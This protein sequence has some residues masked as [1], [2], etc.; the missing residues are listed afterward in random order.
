MNFFSLRISWR[1]LTRFKINTIINLSGLIAA[2]TAAILILVYIINETSFDKFH[3]H[4]D[5]IY[6]LNSIIT[7]ADGQEL[8]AATTSGKLPAVLMRQLPEIEYI[9]RYYNWGSHEVVANGNRYSSELIYWVDTSFLDIFS[10]KMK[11]S[12]AKNCLKE[13]NSIVLTSSAARRLFGNMDPIN[14]TLLI[15]GTGYQVTGLMEDVPSNSHMQFEMLASFETIETPGNG[16]TDRNGLSFTFYL[17]LKPGTDY[18]AFY[19]K[20]QRVADQHTK[21]RFENTGFSVKHSL[22][23]LDRVHLYSN[24]IIDTA[25]SGDIRN[26]RIFSFMALFILLIASMNYINLMTAQSEVRMRETGLLKVLGADRIHLIRK[27][28]IESLLICFSALILAYGI[29][30]LLLHSFSNIMDS[31][32]SEASLF[33]GPI[34]PIMIGV[35]LVTGIISGFYPAWI[36]SIS[37][38]ATILKGSKGN[39]TIS[40]LSKYLVAFQFCITVFLIIGVVL[41]Q[42]QI[43]YMKNID[44]GFKKTDLIVVNNV[45]DKIR[46]SYKSIRAEMLA[47]PDIVDVTQGQTSPGLPMSVQN[48]YK[49]GDDPNTAFMINEARVNDHYL[50]TYGIKLIS[51]R[52]F[53]QDMPTDSASFIINKSAARKLGLKDPVGTKINVWNTQGTII[54]VVSDFHFTS[55]HRAVEPLVF[56]HHQDWFNL[57]SV[58]LR[59]GTTVRA[60][61]H[62]VK[63]LKEADPVYNIEYAFVDQTFKTMYLKEER[64]NDLITA[65]SILAIIISVMGLFALT[66]FTIRRRVKEVGIRKTMGASAKQIIFLL[67]GKVLWWIL[68]GIVV[69]F[70]LIWYTMDVWL[71]NFAYHINLIDYWW[72][73]ISGAL[74]SVLVGLLSV[75]FQAAKAARSNPVTS[76]QYE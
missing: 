25:K 17:M 73:W 8:K 21:E 65:G 3:D 19:P 54:G 43:F 1:I 72:V 38:P 32:L 44:L 75:Y 39:K 35:A 33:T 47:S 15:D 9:S 26:I 11:E 62:I 30:E 10:F 68:P 61:K 60:M 59:P 27:F 13:P 76:L 12:E 53:N 5:R 57:I 71:S 7:M 52:D 18:A 56:T 22:Q 64:F 41:V 69:A 28:L 20:F 24:L 45:T 36:G 4:G 34:V 40:N 23:P 74:F 42:Q 37:N 6:R 46:N 70:P 51:G 29:A 63:V 31:D 66:T 67:A 49:V 14:K 58:R 48:C 55:M 16:I 50:S 2:F